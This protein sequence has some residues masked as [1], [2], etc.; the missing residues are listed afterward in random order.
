MLPHFLSDTVS[1]SQGVGRQESIQMGFQSIETAHHISYRQAFKQL[2]QVPK[3][4][5]A[6]RP[7]PAL[8]T[9][10]PKFNI[11]AARWDT[12]LS[13]MNRNV[14]ENIS[15]SIEVRY[16][17]RWFSAP[18]WG[19]NSSW[20]LCRWLSSRILADGWDVGEVVGGGKTEDTVRKA[21]RTD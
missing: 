12:L 13:K 9:I 4:A 20:N 18:K 7:C 1:I 10:S 16:S 6:S 3:S 2:R 15:Y 14:I 11:L 8:L 17:L 5:R 21:R 19:G